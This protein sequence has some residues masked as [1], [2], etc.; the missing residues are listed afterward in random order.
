MDRHYEVLGVE[1]PASV[2]ELR[3]RYRE[4]LTDH[5]PD[6]GGSREEFLRIRSAYEALTG[7]VAPD[8]S[9]GGAIDRGVVDADV[10]TYDPEPLDRTAHRLTVSGEYLTLSLVALVQEAALSSV[11]ATPSS[12]SS[13]TRPVAFFTGR[14]T[15]DHVLQWAGRTETTF[16]GTDGFMYEGSTILRPQT[17]SLP[18]RWWPGDAML[19]PGR[20]LDAVVIAGN[21]PGNVTLETVI[22][23][24]RSPP[25]D[26]K[27]GA[28]ERYL[29]EVDD[30]V[31]EAIDGLP[32][33][34][35]VSR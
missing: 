18:G 7:E 29:F 34:P 2:G 31:R 35:A 8:D 20:A 11:V 22:Y 28:T 16:V 23:S 9:H 14:N 30:D 24:Q 26:G 21:V 25:I 33:D 12:Q 10:P 3:R 19:A 17:A 13:A 27:T 5:H 1:P 15:S 32:Y 4:L 6:Q